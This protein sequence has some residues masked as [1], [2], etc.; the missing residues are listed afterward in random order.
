[1]N[2]CCDSAD[3]VCN[4]CG[5]SDYATGITSN[6][7]SCLCSGNLRWLTATKT[8]GCTSKTSAI[9]VLNDKYD[10]KACSG[11]SLLAPVIDGTKC[12]C[13]KSLVWSD[14]AADCTCPDVANQ[15]YFNNLC[16]TCDDTINAKDKKS[17]TACNCLV[18]TMKWNKVACECNDAKS[19]T[20]GSG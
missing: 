2:I 12:T 13:A 5:S 4:Y 7:Q 14:T 17:D 19:F 15:I 20:I 16:I 18:T 9:V 11:K 1:M 6:K 10:C 8:C 3:T